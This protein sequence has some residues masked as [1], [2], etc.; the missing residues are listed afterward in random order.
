MGGSLEFSLFERVREL[1]FPEAHSSQ[2]CAGLKPGVWHSSGSPKGVQ[3]LKA[4]GRHLP[5]PV[6]LLAGRWF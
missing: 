1:P 3:G 4:L 5:P 6:C 2:G